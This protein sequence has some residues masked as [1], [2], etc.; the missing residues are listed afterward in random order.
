M[1]RRDFM[2]LPAVGFAL[3]LT[4]YS[5]A[6]ELDEDVQETDVQWTGRQQI[7]NMHDFQAPPC[8]PL[9]VG[10]IGLGNRGFASLQRLAKMQGVEIRAIADCYEY[11]V[12]RAQDFLKS[13]N[14]P[15]AAE[16]FSSK[17][18]WKDLC[19]RDDLDVIYVTTPPYLHAEMAV[20][21]MLAGKHAA[22]EVP[23][24]QTLRDC[25]RLVDTSEKTGKHCFILENCVYDFFESM[26][27]N[28]AQKGFFGEIIHGEGAYCHCGR[29]GSLYS[30]KPM[31]PLSEEASPY[32]Q[33]RL[34]LM[35]GNTYPTHGFGPIAKAMGILAGDRV[36]YLS[37]VETD[38]FVV[39]KAFAEMAEKTNDPYFKQFAGKAHYGG[40]N[41][42][43]MRTV[44]GKTI[45][46]DY[47]T[48]V[49][50][51]YSRV[52]LL[53]GT[54]AFCQKN[55]TPLISIG[56]D[57]P[58]SEEKMAELQKEFA[59]ELHV[60][61]GELAKKFGGHGGMDFIED[62]RFVNCLQNGLAP[63][64]DVY[65]GALWSCITPL[66]F[67]SITHRSNSIDVPDFTCGTWKTN[68]PIDL[69]LR[70][71]GKNTEMI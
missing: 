62:W 65:D 47:H 29:T 42:S 14:L 21:A 66:S 54:K 13:R 37:S 23:M 32:Y 50:R 69:S 59:P 8:L 48:S 36:E 51:P 34:K 22:T 40:G 31:P 39:G 61:I 63:D 68:K 67:W 45:C 70:N 19:A 60:Y 30:Q 6:G 20:H 18:S 26:T 44:N 17:E 27:I 38:D 4:G 28:M 41:S 49:G 43:I 55:P 9:R 10:Y 33:H 3:G 58:V 52:H 35:R 2:K 57:Q 53:S 12:R 46:L 71:G 5:C 16:Y 15:E 1:K 56:N 7:R 11:P 24:A 64:F 25:I